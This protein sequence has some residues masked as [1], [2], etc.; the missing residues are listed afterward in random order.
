[1]DSDRTQSTKLHFQGYIHSRN[2]SQTFSS[3]LGEESQLKSY[4]EQRKAQIDN[5]ISLNK[6][7]QQRDSFKKSERVKEFL[8]KVEHSKSKS[9]EKFR[10]GRKGPVETSK[11]KFLQKVSRFMNSFFKFNRRRRVKL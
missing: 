1:M 4:R 11:L 9:K 8:R 10:S 5:L 6:L 7:S 2:S 3:Q